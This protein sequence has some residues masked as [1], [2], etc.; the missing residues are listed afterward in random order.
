MP[1]P[2]LHKIAEQKNGEG[3]FIYNVFAFYPLT[4]NAYINYSQSQFFIKAPFDFILL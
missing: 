2:D 4:Q 1:V 3:P